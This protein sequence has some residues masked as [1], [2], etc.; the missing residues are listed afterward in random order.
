MNLSKVIT[1]LKNKKNVNYNKYLRSI[2]SLDEIE[3]I[4]HSYDLQAGSYI[5]FFLQIFIF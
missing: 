3:I 5:K 4:K 2:G 1:N